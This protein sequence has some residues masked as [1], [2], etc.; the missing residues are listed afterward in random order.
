HLSGEVMQREAKITMTH[1]PYQGGGEA[2]TALI[3]SNVDLLLTAAPTAMTQTQG[4]RARA[5]A[6]T[7]AK[8]S[9]AFPETPTF[10]ELGYPSFTI[11][12]WYGLAA[13]R[14]RRTRCSKKST[15][16]SRR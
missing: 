10:V 2:L 8:R 16:R 15:A 7:G 12:N 4:G 1:I 3:G 14:A 13:R 5:L 9:I 6:V 11:A